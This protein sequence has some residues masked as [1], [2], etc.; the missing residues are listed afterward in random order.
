MTKVAEYPEVLRPVVIRIAILV[1][2]LTGTS[3]DPL[4]AGLTSPP[5]TFHE[6]ILLLPR[7]HAVSLYIGV[8]KDY[9][10]TYSK[11]QG[12]QANSAS[13]SHTPKN[14]FLPSILRWPRNPA[15]TARSIKA[16]RSA[17]SLFGKALR[18]MSPMP[19][20]ALWMCIDLC[21][22]WRTATERGISRYFWM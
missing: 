20:R 17:S 4:A 9:T 3:V 16:I 15:S 8:P 18:S 7:K 1:V 12:M 13:H 11:S 10:P 22:I 6:F 19:F 21:G 2:N 14:P 5:S